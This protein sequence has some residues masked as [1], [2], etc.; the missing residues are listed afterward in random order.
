VGT[1]RIPIAI[2]VAV[3][4][5]IRRYEFFSSFFFYPLGEEDV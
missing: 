2:K 3:V 5:H 4:D 1:P